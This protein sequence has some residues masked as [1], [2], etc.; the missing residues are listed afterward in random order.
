MIHI[1]I[2]MIIVIVIVI[3]IVTVTVT[4]TVIVIVI[5]IIIVIVIVIF[6]GVWV[7]TTVIFAMSARGKRA[8]TAQSV[9][10]LAATHLHS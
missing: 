6:E 3:V 4:V 7:L 1:I 8:V 2:V 5:V 10:A 9:L